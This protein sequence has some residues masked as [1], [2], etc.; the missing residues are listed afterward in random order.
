[1]GGDDDRSLRA[2]TRSIAVSAINAAK[3]YIPVASASLALPFYG[4]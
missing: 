4:W 2:N 1:M 3:V